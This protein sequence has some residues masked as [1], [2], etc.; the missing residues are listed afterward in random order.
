MNKI[1][2]AT[3]IFALSGPAIAAEPIILEC[4][5][6]KL[7]IPGR[8]VE[9]QRWHGF[10]RIDRE[11]TVNDYLFYVEN[12]LGSMTISRSSGTFTLKQNMPFLMAN[13]LRG[14]VL[15]SA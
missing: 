14:S 9:W 13:G 12:H 11:W 6:P 10:I 3:L 7:A 15:V 1:A 4:E 5:L 2:I 8:N